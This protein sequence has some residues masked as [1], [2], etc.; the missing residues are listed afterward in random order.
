MVCPNGVIT[1]CARLVDR[2]PLAVDDCWHGFLPGVAG[3]KPSAH[4]AAA[5]WFPVQFL[6]FPDGDSEAGPTVL[7]DDGFP[8]L[9]IVRQAAPA[10]LQPDG[11]GRHCARR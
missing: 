10:S 4:S 8:R 11:A 6:R 9:R 5:A 7:A 3:R 1:D 2:W